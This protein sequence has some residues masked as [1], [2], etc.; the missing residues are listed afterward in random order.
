M[1]KEIDD[2][3]LDDKKTQQIAELQTKYDT[4]K[5]EQENICLKQE[6]AHKNREL[7]TFVRNLADK[8]KLIEHIQEQMAQYTKR[9]DATQTQIIETLLT[10]LKKNMD[11]HQI[12]QDF[13]A[14]F[15]Q[16]HPGY[17]NRLRTTCPQL[18]PQELKVCALLKIQLK[19]TEIVK[20]MFI[21]NQSLKNYRYRIRKKLSLTRDQKLPR[22]LDSI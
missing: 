8:N 10:H 17:Y 18:T 7:A 6:L 16:A 22:Y 3:I 15:E 14:R 11:Y 12:W 20:V 19:S 5:I 4:E 21:D 9:S 2:A 13:E 1:F